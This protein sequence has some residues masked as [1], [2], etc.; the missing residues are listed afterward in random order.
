MEITYTKHGDYYLPDL[1]L[2]EQ[3]PATYGHFSRMRLKYLK[4]H[5]R[6]T[7]I[8]QLISSQLTR[9]RSKID[10]EATWMLNFLIKQI[11]WVG[12]MS[13]I[14]N[15]TSVIGGFTG[16]QIYRQFQGVHHSQ[17]ETALFQY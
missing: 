1:V 2:P 8:T 6:G 5:C 7:Y 14:Y 13:N 4:G 15:A 12:A 11:A 3:E 9:H 17:L 16:D 10:Q